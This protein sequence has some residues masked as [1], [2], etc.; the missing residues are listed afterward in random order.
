MKKIK[1]DLT[2]SSIDTCEYIWEAGVGFSQPS[3]HNVQH[4]YNRIELLK[5]LLTSFSETVYL[6][7]MGK[8]FTKTNNNVLKLIANFF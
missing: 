5:L 7:P 3:Q 6:P 8:S 2:R 1:D 4:D